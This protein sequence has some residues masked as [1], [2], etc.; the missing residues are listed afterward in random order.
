MPGFLGGD[1]PP[2]T[3][4]LGQLT[5]ERRVLIVPGST[6][7]IAGIGDVSSGAVGFVRKLPLAL[8]LLLLTAGLALAATGFHQGAML[9]LAT[10]VCS[11]L[12][13]LLVVAFFVRAEEHCL[14]IA[15]AGGQLF[16]F[17]GQRK[18][19]EEARRLLTDKINS[20]DDSAVYRINFAKGIINAAGHFEPAG[21]APPSHGA[22]PGL[23]P[24]LGPAHGPAPGLAPGPQLPP[25]PARM[26]GLDL[27]MPAM[28]PPV[29]VLA[30]GHYPSPEAHI[31]YAIVLPQI[32]DMQ[33][34]YAQRPDTQEIAERLNE[35]EFLMRSGTPTPAGRAR[36]GQL[37]G[38][39][40]SILGAYPHVVHI[41]QQA[42]RLAGA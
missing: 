37:A 6:I 5:I 39:L 14:S 3:G 9:L 27:P 7:P 29:P 36:L 11:L 35:L 21:A 28:S 40:G 24:A 23:G 18:T 1:R 17:T 31:D 33:R 20:G 25:G 30:N 15:S 22:P 19:L 42:A 16:L 8:A 4:P 13:G 34:F 2:R 12:G 32:V 26:G 41:F 10:G 38:E